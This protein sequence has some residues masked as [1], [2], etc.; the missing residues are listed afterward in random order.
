MATNGE[1][2]M[3][4]HD[5]LSSCSARRRSNGDCHPGSCA[6]PPPG[7]LGCSEPT[8][9]RSQSTRTSTPFPERLGDAELDRFSAS[10]CTFRVMGSSECRG[11]RAGGDWGGAETTVAA[12][13]G[14]WA[15]GP[16]SRPIRV[17]GVG[18]SQI[19]TRRTRTDATRQQVDGDERVGTHRR[20]RRR[21]GR[22]DGVG[23][24]E[25][26]SMIHAPSGTTCGES[27]DPESIAT[28]T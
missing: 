5:V 25:D 28:S 4:R 14:R 6:S 8:S 23:A 19:R 24:S 26:G 10:G 18:D 20:R 7:S 13:R 15:I 9:R 1:Y 3:T 16:G 12:R 11:E 22:D 2:L 27:R 21:G 17:R